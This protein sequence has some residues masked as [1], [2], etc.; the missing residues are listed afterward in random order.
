MK[1]LFLVIALAGCTWERANVEQIE[2]AI[3]LCTGNSGLSHIYAQ[4][5]NKDSQYVSASC[6]NGAE[7]SWQQVK[8]EAGL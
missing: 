2:A 3:R 8:K 7:F 5:W 4:H 6:K 1:S